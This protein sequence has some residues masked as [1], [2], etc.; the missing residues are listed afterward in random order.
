MAPF[1]Q[2]LFVELVGLLLEEEYTERALYWLEELKNMSVASF[3]NNPALKAQVLDE[4]DLLL[5][6]TLH[7]RLERLR[8]GLPS[9]TPAERLELHK[10]IVLA[11]EQ[12]NNLQRRVIRH[13]PAIDLDLP[14][15]QRHLGRSEAIVHYSLLSGRSNDLLMATLITTSGIYMHPIVFTNIE[16][17]RIKQLVEELSADRLDLTEL[18]WLRERVLD[19]LPL[20]GNLKSLYVIPD[21]F[22]YELPLEMFPQGQVSG[23][24]AYGETHY[25]VESV[26]ISYANSLRDLQRAFGQQPQRSYAIDLLAMGISIFSGEE[27]RLGTGFAL[28]PLPLAEE[29]VRRISNRLDRTPNHRLFLAGESRESAFRAHSS[30]ARIIHIASHSE[31][32][33]SDPLYSLIYLHGDNDPHNPEHDGHIYAYEL[34]GMNLNSEMVVLNSCESG[35]G[36]YIQGSGIMGFSRAVKYAGAHSLMMNLWKIRDRSAFEL[37]VRFYEN[38]NSGMRKNEALREAKKHHI[39]YV[40]SNPLHWAPLVMYGNVDALPNERRYVSLI[41]IATVLFLLL[42]FFATIHYRKRAF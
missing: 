36:S 19:P 9:A 29:E 8:S 4:S 42:A 13:A 16:I 39:N 30:D 25:L 37:S 2:D 23:P 11:L 34:F 18:Q 14:G 27:S 15:L 41:T 38:L 26:A 1:E 10:E 32:Y 35:A 24:M 31:V 7:N 3:Y 40:N 6:Y 22:L 17:E 5:D 21:G 20:P 12:L 28:S 33:E